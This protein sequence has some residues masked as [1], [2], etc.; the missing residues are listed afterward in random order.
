MADVDGA[1]DVDEVDI[2]DV[3]DVCAVDIYIYMMQ[4]M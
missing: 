4:M 3:E 2:D 1:C